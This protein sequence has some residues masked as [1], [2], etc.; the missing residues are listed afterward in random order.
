VLVE[1]GRLTMADERQILAEAAVSSDR[2][3]AGYG[4]YDPKG[5]DIATAFPPSYRPFG[6]RP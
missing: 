3:W 2:V 5:H 1:N 6:A 4:G